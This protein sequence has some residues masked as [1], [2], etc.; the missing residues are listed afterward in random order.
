MLRMFAAI[1][2][3]AVSFAP[4]ASAQSP[5]DTFGKVLMPFIGLLAEKGEGDRA[6]ALSLR[7]EEAS[8]VAPELAGAQ[9]EFA[10]QF[11]DRVRLSAPLFGS[12]ITLCRRGETVW[13]SPGSAVKALLENPEIAARLPEPN[14]EF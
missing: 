2:V 9:A 3:V 1:F 8:G 10:L 6:G 12:R 13:V 7:V 14:R 4:A 5:Y 11:P